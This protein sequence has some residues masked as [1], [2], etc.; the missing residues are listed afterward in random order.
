M[1]TRPF[2][3]LSVPSRILLGPGPSNVHARVLRAMQN[4]MLGY[5]DYD[6][7]EIMDRV[8]EMLRLVFQTQNEMTLAITGTGTAGME[9]AMLN[10][11]EPDDV[12]VIGVNGFFGD[13]MAN[14]AERSGATIARVEHEWGTLIDVEAVEEELS[15]HPSVKLLGVVHGET[16]TGVRQPLEE[17]SRLAKDYEALF[18]VDAVATL[19]G[20]EVE[21][22]RWGIDFCFSATQKCIGAPPSMSPVTV[23]YWGASIIDNRRTRVNGFYKDL[24]LL[25]KYW[26]SMNV[27]PYHHTAPV[28]SIYALYEALRLIL[29]EGLDERL[30]R[31]RRNGEAFRSGLSA[32]G[33]GV[34][35]PEGY[36][37]NQLHSVLVP[38][39]VDADR[40]KERLLKEHNVEIGAGIGELRGKIWRIG[41]MGESS[42][43]ANVLLL[44]HLLERILP[45][46]G[47]K[48]P[49][50]EGVA[51]AAKILVGED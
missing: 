28:S 21:P 35:A 30:S 13:R 6:L 18:V 16:S 23:G 11:L 4:P 7:L 36:R 37:L 42:T 8:T 26:A 39:G 1:T 3:E 41:F 20:S 5:F 10:L 33:L 29:E 46:E 49:T 32:L 50:G 45:H 22:D 19:G 47:F 17:L 9:T 25:R 31:H 48:V 27:R 34:L 24:S 44:L 38:E 12:A 40:V 2:P 51:A 14:I 43:E 15:R